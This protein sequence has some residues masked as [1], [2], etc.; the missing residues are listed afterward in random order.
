ML[1]PFDSF[2][3]T[4]PTQV[5]IDFSSSQAAAHKLEDKLICSSSTVTPMI[6]HHPPY[7]RESHE[8]CTYFSKLQPLPPSPSFYRTTIAPNC[9][10]LSLWLPPPQHLH[11]CFIKGTYLIFLEQISCELIRLYALERNTLYNLGKIHLSDS[12]S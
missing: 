8:G 7:S 10:Q 11:Q 4:S 1:L 9:S 5:L 6:P 3:S 2:T 12:F